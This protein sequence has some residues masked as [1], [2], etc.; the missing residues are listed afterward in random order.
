M[1]S[2]L[3]GNASVLTVLKPYDQVTGICLP[4]DAQ[5]FPVVHPAHG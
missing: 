3:K 5:D 2:L 1:Q 4:L